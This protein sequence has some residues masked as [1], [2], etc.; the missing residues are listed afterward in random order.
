M[1]EVQRPTW[2]GASL[3]CCCH[4]VPPLPAEQSEVLS[5]RGSGEGK[6]TLCPAR[7]FV[8]DY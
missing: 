5:W 2:Q 3:G 4:L 6:E 7:A 1:K 8:C